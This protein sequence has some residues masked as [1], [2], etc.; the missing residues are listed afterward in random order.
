M[1]NKSRVT[2]IL[3]PNIAVQTV[4]SVKSKQGINHRFHHPIRIKYEKTN[5]QIICLNFKKSA[6]GRLTKRFERRVLPNAM[7]F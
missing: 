7:P 4:P 6:E 2:I 5:D 3:T 1:F